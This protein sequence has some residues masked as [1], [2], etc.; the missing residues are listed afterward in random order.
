M[1]RE[2]FLAP[3]ASIRVWAWVGIVAIVGHALLRAYIK[4]LMNDW[5]QRFYDLGGSALEVSS[6]D[7]DGLATGA[8]QIT[9]L[10]IEFSLLCLPSVVV[11]PAF[12]L[13][14]N[15]WVLVWRVALINE[16]LTAWGDSNVHMENSAQRIHEDTQRF[17]RGLQVCCM[18][19][20]D[21]V[22]TIC[23]FAPVLVEL[24][25]KVQPIRLVDA[26]LF[27]MCC[28]IAVVGLSVSVVLGWSLIDLEV[29]NQ[30]VEANIRRHLV[31][32]EENAPRDKRACLNN[33]Q[34]SLDASVRPPTN[35]RAVFATDVRALVQNYKA[36]YF[37]FA[38]F[39]LWLGAYEQFVVILPYAIAGPLLFGTTNRI[40]LGKVT[41]VSNA[42]GNVFDA[43]N[44]LSDRWV[45]VTD[46]L[47]VMRRL[48]EFEAQVY[49]GT[50]TRAALIGGIEMSSET[51]Q[52][53][54][55]VAHER[56][57]GEHE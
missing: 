57:D 15:R 29:N 5:M 10:L 9:K 18:T 26:W 19:V 1:L 23:V 50:S 49:S 43:L 34:E 38:V 16:Y 6:D 54:N 56:T 52:R 47:S 30:R 33:D 32:H 2:F 48:K 45:D 17:A 46:W 28:A 3:R 40:T 4:Y 13:L 31:L 25:R 36:L 41:Q 39:S 21:S 8:R 24:G 14:K 11:H 42:F 35:L 20:L 53:T 55:E 44:I 51:N 12:Q 37:K 7:A 27:L 22:L